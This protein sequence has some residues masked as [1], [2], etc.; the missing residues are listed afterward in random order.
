MT[1]LANYEASNK[2]KNTAYDSNNSNKTHSS[3]NNNNN[4]N[5]NIIIINNNNNTQ[6]DFHRD[7][8]Y[9]VLLHAGHAGT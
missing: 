2:N 7:R 3:S 9:F 8:N 4:N 6:A 5:N 1:G